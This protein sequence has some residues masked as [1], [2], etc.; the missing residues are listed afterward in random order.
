MAEGAFPIGTLA[1]DHY[2]RRELG[3]VQRAAESVIF[4]NLARTCRFRQWMVT[5]TGIEPV[6]QP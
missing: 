4:A 5:P 6:F 2:S 1:A 3:R